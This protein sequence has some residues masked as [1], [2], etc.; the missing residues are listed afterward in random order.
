VD[1]VSPALRE[2]HAAESLRERQILDVAVDLLCEAGYAGMTLDALARRARTSKATL[3][4]R[5]GGKK[6]LVLDVIRLVIRP[7]EGVDTGDLR[8]DLLA[9]GHTVDM[10]RTRA[11]RLLLALAHVAAKD[12]E[13]ARSVDENLAAPYRAAM[14]TAID[15]AISRGE[16]RPG[17]R[18]LSYVADIVPAIALGRR[19]F[20]SAEQIDVEE[21]VDTIV[22]PLL[23]NA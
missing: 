19:V 15:K 2:R 10:S 23:R 13:F 20:G 5:W 22:L 6:Q 9:I 11:P 7:V 17:A 4:G 12:P 14:R 3:Y 1:A 8:G 18:D 16:L 21:V